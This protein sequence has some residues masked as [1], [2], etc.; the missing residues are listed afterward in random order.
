MAD[1]LRAKRGQKKGLRDMKLKAG[2]G[3]EKLDT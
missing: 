1:V 3:Q 2:A